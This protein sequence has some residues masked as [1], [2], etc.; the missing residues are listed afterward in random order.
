MGDKK[1]SAEESDVAST[2][3]K[4]MLEKIEKEPIDP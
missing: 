2:V 4:R 1:A 3:A